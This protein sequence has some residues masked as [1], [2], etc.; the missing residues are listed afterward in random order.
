MISKV[1]NKKPPDKFICVKCPLNHILKTEKNDDIFKN[2]YIKL[3][4]NDACFRTNQIIIH[5]YQFIRLWIL[6]KYH[7][8]FDIPIIDKNMLKIIFNVLSFT[9]KKGNRPQGEN[10]KLLED[11]EKFYQEHY[12][13][14]NYDNKVNGEYLTQILDGLATDMLTNIENNVKL[15]FFKYLN[16]FVNSSSPFQGFQSKIGSCFLQNN[17]IINLFFIIFMSIFTFPHWFNIFEIK[18]CF[19]FIQ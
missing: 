8:K 3:N 2:N 13:N 14:L 19:N 4:I 17:N 12:K 5:T 1:K 16:R 18:T 7:N 6:H 10:L 9:S 15:H 11:F